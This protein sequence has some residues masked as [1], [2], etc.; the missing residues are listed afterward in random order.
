MKIRLAREEEVKELIELDHIA[1][2]ES[3]KDRR[4]FIRRSVLN[5]RCYVAVVEKKLVGYTVLEYDFWG[6]GGGFI[7]M[8]Q[9]KEAFRRRGIGS[10]LMKYVENLCKEEKLW[11]STNQSNRPMQGLLRKLGFERSGIIY[12]LDPSDPELIYLKRIAHN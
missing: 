11:T 8:L 6:F 5:G 3:R 4:D 12:N 2:I 10:E 7:S 9:V 1:R